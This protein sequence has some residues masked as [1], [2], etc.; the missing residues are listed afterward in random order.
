MSTGLL[1]VLIS[2]ATPACASGS[3]A[4]EQGARV[5]PL[6][7]L[8]PLEE[9]Q[10]DEFEPAIGEQI[11]GAYEK[12]SQ[13]PQDAAATGKL[14]MIFQVYG[15][16]ELAERCF[17]RAKGLD[18]RSFRW[19]YYLGNVEG[20]L[21]KH[22]EAVQHIR[23]AL[24]IDGKYVPARVR[25]AQLL[26]DSG[27]IEQ[28]GQLY[29][30]AAK[31]NPELAS[32]HFGLGQ[33]LA[34]R[35]ELGTAIESYKR[36]CQLAKNYAA[37]H[38]ALG[39]AYRKTGDLASAR[40]YLELYQRLKQAKQPAFDPL[41]EE[42]NAL[43]SGGLTHFAKGSAL[44]QQGKLQEAAAEFEAALNVNPGMVMAH[45]NLIA[46]CGQL[47][48]PEK[49]EQHFRAAVELDPGWVESYYNWGMFLL[50]QGKKAEAAE[51]FRKAVAV[52]PSYPDAQVQLGSLLDES[53][54]QAEAATYYER[55]LAADAGH[56][57]A[58]YLLA[59]NL[60]RRGQVDEA[61]RHFLETIKVEDNRTPVCMQSLAVA[62]ERSGNRQQAL[63]YMEQAHRRAV[64]FGMRDLAS[65]LQQD[66]KRLQAEGVRR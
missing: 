28:A 20:F 18:A 22:S 29:R 57:Q 33:V 37:A 42:V 30:E 26:F 44:A 43:Y 14:G 36:A 39:M 23:E 47:G 66:L 59:H 15:K 5:A 48:Q 49:A 25:L 6:P 58:H 45:I 8:I 10:L 62:Y 11:R 27:D 50:Q 65:R 41:M 40:T 35:E 1:C 52:N 4:A 63:Y 13:N 7:D 9:L 31:Q 2:A 51:M 46:M 17:L 64:S 53:G 19:A 12:A 3:S 34:A 54:R 32:A 38:Y 61:I 56:R 55:A 16:Y 24:T 60:V 21:G